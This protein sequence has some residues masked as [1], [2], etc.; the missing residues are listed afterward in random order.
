MLG[1]VAV[2]AP[3]GLAPREPPLHLRHCKL[4]G[5]RFAV[6]RVLSDDL[7]VDVRRLRQ[8]SNGSALVSAGGR[9]P[10]RTPFTAADRPRQWL[11]ELLLS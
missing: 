5:Q 9:Q 10:R 8:R 3:P 2:V 7:A 1:E 11:L 6:V 4:D